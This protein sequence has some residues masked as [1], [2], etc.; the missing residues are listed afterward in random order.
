MYCA[1][2]FL[3]I[4]NMIIESHYTFLIMEI[5]YP[6]NVTLSP[7]TLCYAYVASKLGKEH[8][9]YTPFYLEK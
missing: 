1:L 4:F 3:E 2:A 6:P 7:R 5:K 9:N 8:Y